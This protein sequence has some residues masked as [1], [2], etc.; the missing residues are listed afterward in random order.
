MSL[1][2]I[3]P[4]RGINDDGLGKKHALHKLISQAQ[5]DYVWL[6]DDDIT[7]PVATPPLE[8]DL[9]ILPLHMQGDHSLLQRLQCAEYA[10]IQYLTIL[11]AQH[12]HAV[13]CSGANLIVHRDRWLESYP[14]L[15]PQIPSGDDMFL[16]QSFKRRHLSIAVMDD[17]RYTATVYAQS[18]WRAFFRQRMR[19]AGKAPHYSDKDIIYCGLIVLLANVLQLLCPLVLLIKFP[20]EYHMVK[21]RDPKASF[22]IVL[23]LEIV[24]PLYMLICLIGGRIRGSW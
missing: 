8:A 3:V 5:T 10:A 4:R 20:I 21:K 2:V 11:S 1:T 7:P 14:D 16:L 9:I 12:G 23:L 22:L 15:Y 24:Y 6:Q 17:P 13:M 18:S 19:W